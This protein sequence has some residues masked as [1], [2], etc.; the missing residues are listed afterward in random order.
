LPDPAEVPVD[1]T[2]DNREFSL[3]LADNLAAGS[4]PYRVLALSAG[5]QWGAFGAGVLAG[6]H[7]AGADMAFDL[8]TGISTGALLAPLAFLGE[9]ETAKALYTSIQNEDVYRERPILGLLQ[10][11]SLVDTAPLR[12]R[13]AR[14]IDD[15]F[16]ARIAAEGATGR[17]LAVQAINIDAGS[18]VVFDLTA[19]ALKQS[20]PCGVGV[21]PRDCIIQA[22][23]AAA[24]IPVAFPP[25]FINGDMYV[26]GGLRQHA[27]TLRLLRTV[28]QRP[29]EVQRMLRLP[30]GGASSGSYRALPPLA[31][32]ERPVDLTLIANSDFQIRSQCVDNGLLAVANRSAGVAVDQLALGSFYRLM[33]ET[34]GRNNNT[35]RFTYADPALTGCN[36]TPVTQKSMQSGVIDVFDR[37]YMRCLFR[38]ACLLSAE[39]NVLLWRRSPDE[40]PQ[41]PTI[42]VPSPQAAAPAQPSRRA[43]AICELSQT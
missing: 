13:V 24:A 29:M 42:N 14:I 43:P 32:R 12:A 22:V 39:G 34:L 6:M 17:I 20:M 15:G 9:F 18:S 38:Q 40:L 21:A 2:D 5:G 11:N 16:V 31:E 26:D 37:P 25:E 36:F 30:P 19:I 4:G 27:F 41:S 7:V 35:A 33:S 1:V 8:V 3:K 23:M 10:A 28:A